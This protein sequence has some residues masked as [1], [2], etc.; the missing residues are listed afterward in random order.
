MILRKPTLVL[1]FFCIIMLFLQTCF[2]LKDSA[3]F[4]MGKRQKSESKIL[5]SLQENPN[6]EVKAVIKGKT[7]FEENHTILITQGIL[8]NETSHDTVNEKAS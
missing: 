6:G 7:F 4:L 1:V 2:V 3:P 5:G 8:F